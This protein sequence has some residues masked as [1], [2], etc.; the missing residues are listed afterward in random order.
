MVAKGLINNHRRLIGILLTTVVMMFG[1]SFA[2]VP[3]YNAFCK[4]TGLQGKY[5][6]GRV[7]IDEFVTIDTSRT[8]TVHFISQVVSDF[9]WDFYPTV[10]SV[11]VHPGELKRVTFEARNRAG[12]DTVGQAIPSIAPG[13]ASLYFH[14]TECFC[15]N[16]QHLA[17][18]EQAEMPLAFYLSRDMPEEIEEL[19]LSYTLFDAAD[20]PRA[21]ID[22]SSTDMENL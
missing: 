16:Q 22:I 18:G 6:S 11:K 20:H 10:R 21:P 5:D 14:K 1:F 2:L 12:R 13:L 9:A 15:F 7:K 4:V 8:I 3:L 19:T 17:K